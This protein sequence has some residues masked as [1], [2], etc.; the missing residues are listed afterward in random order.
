MA[1]DC[2]SL[3]ELLCRQRRDVL[4]A[5]SAA[6]VGAWIEFDLPL[7]LGK[8]AIHVALRMRDSQILERRRAAK[9]IGMDVIQVDIFHGN[10]RHAYLA[11]RTISF[12]HSPAKQF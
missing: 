12:D 9:C 3:G 5:S 8:A 6:M 7:S 1:N 2:I 10:R 4:L 11:N